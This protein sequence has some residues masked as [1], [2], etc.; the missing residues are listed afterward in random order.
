[1]KFLDGVEPIIFK[2]KEHKYFTKSGKELISVSTIIKL[3]SQPFDPTG[4]ILIRCAEKQGKTPDELRKEWDYERDSS[5]DRGHKLHK[6]AEYWIENKKIDKKGEFV[7]VIKQLKNIQFKGDLKSETIL[8]DET[9]GLA[10]TAD[11]IDIY[12]NCFIDLWDF[13]QNKAIK[14][15]SFFR[16]GEGYQMM[17]YPIQH[18]MDCNY[19][20]YSLQLTIY[21][22]LLENAGYWINNTTLLY[23][24]PKQRQ[25][26]QIPVPSLRKEALAIIN[27]YNKTKK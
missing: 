1:M 22:L 13:K 6:E 12:N 9:L 7:D 15:S 17:Q 24:T 27:H 14:K 2:E 10:G 25:L 21:S 19:V 5:C 18:L 23:L 3:Y 26:K 8:Y 16:R 11:L 4:E 20:H